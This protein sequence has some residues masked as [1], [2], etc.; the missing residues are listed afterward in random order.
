MKS[1]NTLQKKGFVLVLLFIIFIN[2]SLLA[3]GKK[4]AIVFFILMFLHKL[5]KGTCKKCL[6]LFW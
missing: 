6:F 3:Q 5:Q 2:G 4:V 1:Q